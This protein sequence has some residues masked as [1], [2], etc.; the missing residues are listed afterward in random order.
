MLSAIDVW[1]SWAGCGICISLSRNAAVPD[2]TRRDARTLAAVS[3]KRPVGG[4]T[5]ARRQHLLNR[6][7]IGHVVVRGVMATENSDEVR[8]PECRES[9]NNRF[10]SRQADLD[11]SGEP[12]IKTR[13]LLRQPLL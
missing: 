1:I 12:I 2:A 10:T 6:R 13:F 3:V 4:T 8:R 9:G 11:V 5:P 7:L